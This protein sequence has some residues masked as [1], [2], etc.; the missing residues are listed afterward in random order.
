MLRDI[1]TLY[2]DM[3]ITLLVDHATE[4]LL[5]TC[6][7]ETSLDGYYWVSFGLTTC[8]RMLEGL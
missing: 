6:M 7:F 5:Q 8:L 3:Q 2:S 4:P 1:S